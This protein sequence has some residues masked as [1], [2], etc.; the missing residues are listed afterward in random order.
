MSCGCNA[1][2]S[3]LAGTFD[4]AAALPVGVDPSAGYTEP[5]SWDTAG[6]GGGGTCAPLYAPTV[7]APPVVA[8]SMADDPDTMPP[9]AEEVACPANDRP[10]FALGL[11][12]GLAG[13]LLLYTAAGRFIP[14]VPADE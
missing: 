1:P 5:A 7:T 14:N 12:A 4:A 2:T 9:E 6:G 13:G 11:L 10:D 3:A 8:S